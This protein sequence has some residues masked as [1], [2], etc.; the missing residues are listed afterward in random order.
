MMRSALLAALVFLAAPLPSAS[1]QETPQGSA[2]PK[3][4]ISRPVWRR[5]PTG[6]DMARVHPLRAKREKV[7]G[8]VVIRC[9]ARKDGHLEGCEIQ[10]ETPA[11]Y[12][13]GEAAI[14]LSTKFVMRKTSYEGTPVAG[15]VVMI[16]V[17]F[18]S[19]A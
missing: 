10:R 7:S 14:K 15:A 19:P 9:R 13:F 2:P 17:R 6:S 3:P 16:P 4:V 5:L 11:G 18:R 8:E 1:G 12:D